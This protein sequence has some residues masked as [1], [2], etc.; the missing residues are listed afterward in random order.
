MLLKSGAYFKPSKFLDEHGLGQ[1]LGSRTCPILLL[2]NS[3]LSPLP[4]LF[5]WGGGYNGGDSP[6]PCPLQLQTKLKIIAGMHTTDHWQF[7]LP[8]FSPLKMQNLFF[9]C[10][11]EQSCKDTGDCRLT[12]RIQISRINLLICCVL[13]RNCPFIVNIGSRVDGVWTKLIASLLRCEP[14]ICICITA[15]SPVFLPACFCT[16]PEMKF[17]VF[18]RLKCKEGELST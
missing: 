18:E 2:D 1:W 10:C 9:W 17:G 4:L 16:P 13:T 3:W 14:I 7:F 8:D 11:S 5:F 12:T 15:L 6:H